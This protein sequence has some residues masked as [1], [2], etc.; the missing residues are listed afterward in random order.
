MSLIGVMVAVFA[1]VAISQFNEKPIGQTMANAS[2]FGN[3]RTNAVD[4]VSS[5]DIAAKIAVGVDSIIAQNVQNLADSQKAQVQYATTGGSYLPKPQ[6][7]TTDSKTNKDITNYIVQPG[8]T[9]SSIAKRFNVTSDT[10]K[11]E[12]DIYGD[13]VSAGKK[14]TIL[15]VTGIKYTVK[16]ND[17]AKSIAERYG[18]NQ[19]YLIAF[20]DAELTGLK[21]GQ[22]IIIPNGEKPPEQPTYFSGGYGFVFG[23]Q[24]IYGGGNGYSYGYCT[25][26]AANRRTQVGKPLPNNLG[27]AVT[28]AVLAAQ[29]GFGVGEQPK[30]W[31]AL[32]DRNTGLAGGLGHVAFVEEI[33]ADGSIKV[34]DMN[35]PYWGVVTYREIKPAEFNRYLFIY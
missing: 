4:E 12:N 30:K 29:A 23:S 15:P 1:V 27:N 25:W 26:H 20:N 6:Q 8:D 19:A 34:S 14:L 24:P 9:I 28:W 31:A 21:A 10:I 2:G 11:W 5:A 3:N 22:N 32:W 7:V 16:E 13:V 18:A 17:T 33:N 35:Y